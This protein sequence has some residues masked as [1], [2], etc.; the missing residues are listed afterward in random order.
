MLGD[1]CSRR[2]YVRAGEP[3]ELVLYPGDDHNISRHALQLLDT[4]DDWCNTALAERATG[5]TAAGARP[6]NQ[7]G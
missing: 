2:L 6:G 7:K 3:K 1:S 5:T 4:L